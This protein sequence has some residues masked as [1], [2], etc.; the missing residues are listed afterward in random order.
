[1]A[2]DVKGFQW[3]HQWREMPLVHWHLQNG[4]GLKWWYRHNQ[5]AHKSG[6][7]SKR[8]GELLPQSK[9]N[10]TWLLALWHRIGTMA[11]VLSLMATHLANHSDDSSGSQALKIKEKE[12]YA[13]S[14]WPSHVYT[15]IHRPKG[16]YAYTRTFMH[17]EA[18]TVWKIWFLFLGIWTYGFGP[19]YLVQS[20]EPRYWVHGI[21]SLWFW[22]MVLSKA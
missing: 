16:A 5:I 21:D 6:H 13:G 12:V 7:I 3:Y 4:G 11:Q 22:I 9:E 2:K 14:R 8:F 10:G 19:W 15:Q 17:R 1:M 20:V 18:R